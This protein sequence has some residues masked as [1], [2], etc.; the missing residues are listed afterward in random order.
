MPRRHE[1]AQLCNVK[2]LEGFKQET[3]VVGFIFL[4]DYS[5]R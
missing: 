1:F 4:K 3:V 2:L 5:D